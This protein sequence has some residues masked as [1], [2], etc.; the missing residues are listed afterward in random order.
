MTNEL[1]VEQLLQAY[2]PCAPSASSR[3]GCTWTSPPARFPASVPPVR[4]RGSLGHR[5]LHAPDRARLHRQHPTRPRPLHRQGRGPGGMMAEIWG[6]QTGTC[7]A[8]AAPWHIADLSV[9]MWA[10]QRHRGRRRPPHLRHGAGLQAARR[11]RRGR[12]H[13]SATAPPNQGTIFE[14]N[15][16]GHGMETCRRSSWPRTTGYAEATSSTFSVPATTSPTAPP[17]SACPV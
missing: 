11:P 6:K 7:K 10:R 2:A 12:V 5:H 14:A 4:R 9:G 1:S 13:S 17:P 15:E 3:S 8:R 16:P